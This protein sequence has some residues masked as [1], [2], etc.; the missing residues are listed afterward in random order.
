MPP[1]QAIAVSLL[2]LAI[3]ACGSTQQSD[4][5][6]AQ[7]IVDRRAIG[8]SVGDFF[9]RYGPPSARLDALDGTLTFDWRGGEVGIRA[10]VRGIED[11]ICRL[12]ITADKAGRITAATIMRDAQGQRRLTRCAQLIDG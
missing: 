9:D 10:G 5:T 1:P 2:A 7:R 4:A 8:L 12:R 3:V 11:K 6:E